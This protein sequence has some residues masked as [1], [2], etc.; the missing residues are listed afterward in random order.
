MQGPEVDRMQAW[1]PRG[2][3][4][5]M[6]RRGGTT[7][8]LALLICAS[9]SES[10]P[11]KA[12]LVGSNVVVV[13][14]DALR[15]DRLGTYGYERDTSP[16]LDEFAEQGAV[17][18]S[19][20]SPASQTVPSMI[21]LWSGVYPHHHG[22]Q[23]FPK[24][25][26]IGVERKG[27]RPALPD[28]SSL[29]A[30]SFLEAGYQT[31]AVV[32]NPWL[33]AEYGFGRGFESYVLLDPANSA[34]PY[35]RGD[36]VSFAA[37]MAIAHAASNP[38]QP[39]FLYLHFMD[40]HAPYWPSPDEQAL[41]APGVTD[42]SFYANGRLRG[43]DESKM[44]DASRLYDAEVRTFDGF[45]G[46]LLESIEAMGGNRET[47]V[48][49]TADHGDEFFEHGGMGHG[50]SLYEEVVHVPLVFV[51]PRIP[52]RRIKGPVSL[53][54]FAPTLLA[55]LGL[56]AGSDM[57]GISL[58]Q[59]VR[60]QAQH[61]LDGH[62]WVLSE[63]G[64][65]KLV[66]SGDRKLILARELEGPARVERFDLARDPYEQSRLS[67]AETREWP[68]EISDRAEALL[69]ASRQEVPRER[70]SKRFDP[71]PDAVQE[72]LKALGYSD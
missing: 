4:C 24:T 13:V 39:L 58:A 52:S 12:S 14:V 7:I 22:N 62:R 37:E 60:G 38:D 56:E 25:N 45:L 70:G 72:R 16:I 68:K 42:R 28:S 9:C 10:E 30:E 8:A 44:R 36:E 32:T 20:T 11:E 66:R 34:Y 50:F 1:V 35:A 33:Q 64:D 65:L 19:V 3:V 59:S 26:S 18:D 57:D 21:S 43:V 71:I 17:F 40:V 55:L 41:L 5:E 2:K 6:D 31:V 53:V 15:A 69:N 67:D 63:L 51:H 29:L 54:D 61:G 49:L 27:A 48:V 46:G 23:Y 47:L